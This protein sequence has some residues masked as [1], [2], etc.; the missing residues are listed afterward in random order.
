LTI[1]ERDHVPRQH[2]LGT[3]PPP[4][5]PPGRVPLARL[6]QALPLQARSQALRALGRL[7]AQQLAAPAKGV[8]HEP[9]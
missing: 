1:R 7:V 5:N 2:R 6:W 4:L 9:R 8:P 3:P